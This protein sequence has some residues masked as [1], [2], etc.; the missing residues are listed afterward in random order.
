M[1][2]PSRVSAWRLGFST[3]VHYTGIIPG[4][5]FCMFKSMDSVINWCDH[6]LNYC[7]T[8]SLTVVDSLVRWGD[9]LVLN[10]L[11]NQTSF[12]AV[13]V[14]SGGWT[15]ADAVCVVILGMSLLLDLKRV[16]VPL[17]VG[18]LFAGLFSSLIHS[19]KDLPRESATLCSSLRILTLC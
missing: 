19:N 17:A 7:Q 1:E 8:T 6:G 16:V 14:C 13:C 15:R 9:G 2:P 12:M 3:P 18:W 4:V 11:P 10:N 5:Q